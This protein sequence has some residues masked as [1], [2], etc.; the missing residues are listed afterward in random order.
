MATGA[1][2]WSYYSTKTALSREGEELEPEPVLR[3]LG[4]DRK[5]VDATSDGGVVGRRYVAAAVA[6]HKAAPRLRRLR[7]AGDELRR[8]RRRRVAAVGGGLAEDAET[9]PSRRACRSPGER[10]E[11]RH[12][13]RLPAARR[14]RQ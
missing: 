11:G 8:L 13:L 2:L 12:R 14:R 7:A 1:M 4:G 6:A 5:N 3:V 10:Y 9:A